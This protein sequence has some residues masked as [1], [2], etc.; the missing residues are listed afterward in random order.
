M[1]E[2]IYSILA[3]LLGFFGGGV[4]IWLK[5]K[6][7][8]QALKEKSDIA[9]A[10]LLKEKRNGIIAEMQATVN[11]QS[12]RLETLEKE[13]VTLHTQV[14]A[15]YAENSELR[16]LVTAKDVRVE[17]QAVRVDA[18]Q[19]ALATQATPEAKPQTGGPS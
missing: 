19:E 8:M 13:V 3:A 18:L 17:K 16:R 7:G 15:L 1:N 6:A 11:Y 9:E 14:T 2:W 4:G 5:L 12:A 10:A